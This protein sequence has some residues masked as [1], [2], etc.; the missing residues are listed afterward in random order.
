MSSITLSRM[1][2]VSENSLSFFNARLLLALLTAAPF[3]LRG[4]SAQTPP[5]IR[6]FA[7]RGKNDASH[8]MMQTSLERRL[9]IP[10]NGPMIPLSAQIH[11]S[12]DMA[13]CLDVSEG[14]KEQGTK[15]ILWP[16]KAEEQ[17]WNQLFAF[18]TD[19]DMVHWAGEP[20]FCL[21]ANG[22]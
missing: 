13:K 4:S 11:W 17:A 5:S 6:G 8:E 21:D 15:V 20:Q 12:G 10:E 16:C 14:R 3:L 2:L 18:N 19:N 9:G 22:A 7:E 1:K